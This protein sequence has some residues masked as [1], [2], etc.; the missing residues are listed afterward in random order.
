MGIGCIVVSSGV[1]VLFAASPWVFNNDNGS[2]SN[3]A[4]NCA[5]NCGN[6]VNNDNDNSRRFRASVF[7]A[8]GS[9]GRVLFVKRKK[10]RQP[11]GQSALGTFQI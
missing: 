10:F 4:S 11:V 2:A 3:C 8:A 7:A 1:V 6:N 9:F 5:N